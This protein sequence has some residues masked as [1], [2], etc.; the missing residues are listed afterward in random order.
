MERDMKG[1]KVKKLIVLLALLLSG[2]A[3]MSLNYQHP[4]SKQ[5]YR[6]E[7]AG[8]G[9]LGT[10]LAITMY[11]DCTHRMDEQGYVKVT[12]KEEDKK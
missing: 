9:W 1:G 4:V 8:F 12:G 5:F 6:C 2:C 3:V 7:A 10:P 11:L